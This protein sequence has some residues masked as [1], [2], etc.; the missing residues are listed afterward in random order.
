MDHP[1]IGLS[2]CLI[3]PHVGTATRECR[4]STG[5]QMVHNLLQALFVPGGGSGIYCN[6]L[7]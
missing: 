2:N 7:K 6:R 3:L 4:H 1:L 5:A